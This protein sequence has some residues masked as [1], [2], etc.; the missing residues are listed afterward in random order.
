MNVGVEASLN[1]QTGI[2][3]IDVEAYYTADSPEPTNKFNVAILQNNTLGPQ[4][5]GNQGDNYN[6][7]HRLI[8]MVTGQWGVD[9][10]NTTAGTVYT[11]INS[12]YTVP[13][14]NNGIAVELGEL[15]GRC[16]CL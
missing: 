7:M 5:G 2:M 6:H 3:T 8:D 9:I 14:D 16:I 15:R 13:A 12:P 11:P 10:T 4:V 1:V